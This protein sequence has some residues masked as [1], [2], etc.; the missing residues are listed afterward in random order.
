[1]THDL[2]LDYDRLRYIQLRGDGSKLPAKSWGGYS[3][4]FD[5]AEHVHTHED[6]EI[7]PSDN[8]GIV[9]V[10]SPDHSSFALLI[11]DIDIHKAPDDFDVERVEIPTDTLVTRSQ[12][13]GF[14][15]YFVINGCGRG[16]LNESD[17]NMTA[18]PGFDIDIRGSSV[19]H[20]VVAPADIPGVGGDYEIVNDEPI[21]ATFEPAEAARRIHLDGEPL[22]EFAPDEVG[23]DYEFDVPTE[24]PDEMPTCYHAGLELRKAAP[25]DHPNTHKVNMLTAACGLGA[26]YD[27]EAVA[28]HFCGEYAPVDGDVD[29]SDKEATKYQLGQIERGGYNPPSEQTLRDYGILSEGAH[30]DADCPIEYHGPDSGLSFDVLDSGDERDEDTPPVDLSHFKSGAKWANTISP[31]LRCMAGNADPSGKGTWTESRPVV[32]LREHEADDEPAIGSLVDSG[33]IVDVL[34]DWWDR[35]AYDAMEGEDMNPDTG[36][37]VAV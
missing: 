32:I 5:A 34:I 17:F 22:V 35:G 28:G 30:C 8:W 6:V 3:Q 21:A 36:E 24:A 26:G 7:H 33:H 27:V 15:V 31:D 23:I 16:D 2:A 29:H 37:I 13:G 12:N 20:H 25:D 10:E 18:E 9:D 11:F 14:H 4:D 19:S 1:M